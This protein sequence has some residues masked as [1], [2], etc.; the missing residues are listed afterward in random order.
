MRS[1]QWT[2]TAYPVSWRP[3]QQPLNGSASNHLGVH[4]LIYLWPFPPCRNRYTCRCTCRCI[5]TVHAYIYMLHCIRCA[6][7][8]LWRRCH[9]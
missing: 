4:L 3:F 9:D 6:R 7:G 8:L 1:L 5:C 2:R